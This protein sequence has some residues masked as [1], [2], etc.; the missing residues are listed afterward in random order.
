MFEKLFYEVERN[1]IIPKMFR[2]L[3]AEMMSVD[4]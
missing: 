3:L 4:E 2:A 1:T